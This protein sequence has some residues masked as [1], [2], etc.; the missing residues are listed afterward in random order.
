VFHPRIRQH[1][2]TLQAIS[3]SEARFH[4][5]CRRVLNRLTY[6]RTVRSFRQCERHKD[7]TMMKRRGVPQKHKKFLTSVL[8]S[9]LVEFMPYLRTARGILPVSSLSIIPA[10]Q[11]RS[12]GRPTSVGGDLLRFSSCCPLF[13]G[14]K[15]HTLVSR[16]IA[17]SLSHTFSSSSQGQEEESRGE[18]DA[19]LSKWGEMYQ[20][21]KKGYV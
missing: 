4:A 5:C 20:E 11:S 12:L 6:V 16:T 10:F 9:V 14:R 17:K 21:G 3:T 18:T 15:T 2:T 13:V 1:T 8:I 7:Q 19:D